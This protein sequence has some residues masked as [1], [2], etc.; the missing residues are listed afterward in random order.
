[1]KRLG[2]LFVLLQCCI[3]KAQSPWPSENWNAATNL[4]AIM[5]A[6]GL[7]ELSGLHWNPVTNRLYIV[8]G[9][10]RLRVLQL[11]T[12]TNVFTQIANK[13]ISGGPEGITQA[14][15]SDNIFY[16][17]D[18]NNYEI[19]KYTHT[20]NFSSVTESRHWDLLSANSPMPDTGNTG[21]EGIVFVPDAALAAVGFV[22]QADGLPY[23]S[24]KGAGG[25]FFIASQDGGYIWVYDLNPNAS[26]DFAYIGKYGTNRSESCDLAFDRT[27]N[28]LYILHNVGS[29]YLEVTDMSIPFTA[30]DQPYFP[31]VAE[32]FI[33]N[34]SDGNINIEGFALT[35]KCPES[36]TASAWL[37]RDVESG[38]DDAIKQNA[39][40]WFSPFTAAG[41]CAPLSVRTAVENT[42]ALYPNPGNNRITISI[43]ENDD[44]MISW[45]NVLG[46]TVLRMK[47]NN[48]NTFDVSGLQNG[49]YFVE[50]TTEDSSTIIKW[51]K[52]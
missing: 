3:G 35:P 23:T 31:T 37:C 1:M 6:D 11:N 45:T 2:L 50:V 47:N 33:P 43:S 8:H 26:D 27:T 21:P 24:T 4:T 29:N 9:D 12:T 7:T 42:V 34:P 46:Q 15:Y 28:L 16:T 41:T 13:T 36:G 22:N 25:L 20:A 48:G 44:F 5:N 52:N 30:E 18:E 32:Y 19:K 17:I 10:G 40:K 38:E 49:V 39:L 14:N 51:I